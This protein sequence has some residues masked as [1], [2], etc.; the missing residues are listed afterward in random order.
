LEIKNNAAARGIPTPLAAKSG[1][2]TFVEIAESDA[3]NDIVAALLAVS[4]DPLP[5]PP[6]LIFLLNRLS[7]LKKT[8][9]VFVFIYI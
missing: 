1:A 9:L 7:F 2:A 3:R 8:L 5:P 4:F 6:P